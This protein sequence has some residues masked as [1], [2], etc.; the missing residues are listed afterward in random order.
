MLTK[1]AINYSPNFTTPARNKKNI[2]Y[3]VFHYTGMSSESKAI[4]RLTD[5]KSKVSSHYFIR[6]DGS[7]ILMVPELY[8]AWHAGKSSWKNDKSL[9]KKSIG[10]EVSN[11]GHQFGYQNFTKKQI[12]SLIKL[13]KYLIKKYNIK[14]TNILGHSDIA[15][16]RK[17][18]P[19][20]KFPWEYLSKCNIGM[21]YK[22]NG[23][24]L[25]KLRNKNI[26]KKQEYEF[27]IY[28]SKIGYFKNTK[29]ILNK[30]MLIKNFQRHFR[31]NLINTKIDQE[32]LII[33]KNLSK[34]SLN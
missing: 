33:A 24:L 20:E 7:I 31:Q 19:G 6:R 18:D 9:N 34:S 17:K 25:R 8:E 10:I 28:L 11:K 21:W 32:C 23:S 3:I 1:I 27:F 13:S 29:D 30:N 26:S 15:Y 2:K 5:V 14:K 22:I 4:N 12:N 16:E